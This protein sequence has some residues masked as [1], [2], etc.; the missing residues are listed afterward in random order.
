MQ[1]AEQTETP[2]ITADE[3]IQG[4]LEADRESLMSKVTNIVHQYNQGII[5]A[6]EASNLVLMSG[7][8]LKD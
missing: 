3:I 7:V 4:F 1:T 8:H 5:T 6:E 2:T